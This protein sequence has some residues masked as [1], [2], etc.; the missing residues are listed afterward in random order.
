MAI[1][2]PDIKSDL[3]L[4]LTQF[5]SATNMASKKLNASLKGMTGNVDGFAKT[6]DSRGKEISG[7]WWKRFGTVA[8]GFT[9]AYRAMNVFENGLVKLGLTFKEAILQS[10]QLAEQQAK[11]AFWMTVFA[12]K[13]VS[14]S[15][16]FAQSAGAISALREESI[17]SISSIDELTTGIDEL[18]QAGVP[19]T[20]K[21][22]PQMISLVDF[23]GMVAQTVDSTTRQIRQE[24]QA[25]MDGTSRVTNQLV[26]VLTNMGVLT[27]ENLADLKNMVN[28]A[29]IFEKI[30]GAIHERWT[31][32]VETL[33]KS[34]PERAFAYWEKSIQKVLVESI[35][36]AS[37]LRG[38]DNLFGETLFNAAQKFRDAFKTDD[39]NRMV[40]FIGL[41]NDGLEYLTDLFNDAV[42]GV[43]KLATVIGNS[44]RELRTFWNV[45]G[46]TIAITAAIKGLEMLGKTFIWL[47]NTPL[48]FFTRSVLI[49]FSPLILTAGAMAAAVVLAIG[50]I[51]LASKEL[52]GVWESIKK[53]WDEFLDSDKVKRFVEATLPKSIKKETTGGW[54]LHAKEFLEQTGLKN[55]ADDVQTSVAEVLVPGSP[56]YIKQQTSAFM[57]GLR[58]LKEHADPYVQKL[59]ELWDRL[60]K[61]PD[62]SGLP[63]LG[64]DGANTPFKSFFSDL[65]LDNMKKMEREM[66]NFQAETPAF[67]KTIDALKNGL[68]LEDVAQ[69]TKTQE[70]IAE[71]NRVIADLDKQMMTGSGPSAM[72]ISE[73]EELK[74]IAEG[75]KSAALANI[76]AENSL[77]RYQD[78]LKEFLT[79][80]DDYNNL[81]MTGQQYQSWSLNKQLLD[82]RLL[83]VGNAELNSLIEKYAEAR[84]ASLELEFSGIKKLVQDVAQSMES[85]FS[86]LFF[87]VMTASWEDLEDVATN[88]LRGMQRA[89]SDFFAQLAKEALFG[90][91]TGGG[92]LIGGLLSSYLY[93]GTSSQGASYGFVPGGD[94][95]WYHSGGI[96]GGNVPTTQMPLSLL[97]NA[98]RLHSGLRGDEY[99]A[100]LQRG[101]KVYTKNESPIENITIINNTG[102]TPEVVETSTSTGGRDI[103]I[104]IGQMVA[105]DIYK[106]GPLSQALKQTY[107][108]QNRTLRR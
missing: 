55:A 32:M 15:D 82:L 12:E 35:A 9:I 67:L 69:Y 36:L 24:F 102:S 44:T 96:V 60:I 42:S 64:F 3:L 100:I 70:I 92:S 33:I 16:A 103:S 62:L 14:F 30:A 104:T 4:D 72:R 40:Y 43:A 45:L 56:G 81:T 49:A 17:R 66:K 54:D 95:G 86:D 5:V 48:R 39:M 28:R 85:S 97:E 51:S 29:E 18:A 11:N 50:Q 20:K 21:L 41:L 90:Q 101:E 87:D 27:R 68:R 7:T 99:P 61:A 13:T 108:L 88:A 57:E 73:Y 52:G 106:G 19:I 46:Y 25:L 76:D 84:R 98:V 79:L 74:K 78:Q 94:Y 38:V 83:A 89:L 77:K 93:S 23:T 26:R 80:Q 10:G 63:K 91:Q 71:Y 47:V 1:Q 2:G 58:V 53:K 59:V 75:W 65:T 107:G 31:E 34:S 22:M 8:L 6:M 37:Q 105:K